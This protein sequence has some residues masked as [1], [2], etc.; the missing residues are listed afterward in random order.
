MLSLMRGRPRVARDHPHLDSGCADNSSFH[1]NCPSL[2]I[3]YS[4]SMIMI[5]I[6]FTATGAL[7]TKRLANMRTKTAEDQGIHQQ[8]LRFLEVFQTDLA[9]SRPRLVTKRCPLET[10]DV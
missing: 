3:V 5:S 2:T 1:V 8:F 4:F 10:R 6:L 9:Y 7:E